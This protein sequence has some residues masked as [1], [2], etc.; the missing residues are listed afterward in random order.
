MY[1]IAIAIA[2]AALLAV[3]VFYNNSTI[4]LAAY[5]ITFDERGTP[6][7]LSGDEFV[8]VRDTALSDPRVQELIGGRNYVISDCCGFVQNGSSAPWQPVMNIRVANE[9]QIAVSVDLNARKVTGF[10][11][12]PVTQHQVV[13]SD[14]TAAEEVVKRSSDNGSMVS[15]PFLATN[16]STVLPLI[17]TIGA[18]IG[19]AIAIIF[20]FLKKG[21]DHL[22]TEERV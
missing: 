6:I 1:R 21:D 4:L 11:T 7:S 18:V 8:I 2:S 17:L 3:L 22:A 12:G 9:L 5:A 15:I 20:Y 14:D 13:T 16:S 10:E 19:G